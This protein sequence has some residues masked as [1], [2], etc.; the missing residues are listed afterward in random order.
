MRD[1]L[2]M[3]HQQIADELSRRY[4]VRIARSTVSGAIARAGENLAKRPRYSE[5]TPWHVPQ[6][7]Q[8]EYPLRML[9]LMGRSEQGG[10]LSSVEEQR[11]EA[12]LRTLE[13]TDTV[14]VFCPEALDLGL[15]AFHYAPSQAKDNDGA[16]PIRV[17]PVTPAQ[18]GL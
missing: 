16:I 1:Q 3:T 4:G 9:R 8:M 17:K 5:Y 12:W 14:V 6:E 10:G 18:I 7:A 15:N 11:L 13:E 2:G